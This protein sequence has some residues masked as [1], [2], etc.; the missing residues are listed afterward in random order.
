MNKRLPFEIREALI[1]VC[2]RSFHY[3]D[4]FRDFLISCDVPAEMYE[5]YS[6]D[7]KFKIARHLLA[8]LDSMGDGGYL[9]QKRIITNL[10]RF[11]KLPDENVPDRSA[12][13]NA[14]RNLKHLALDQKLIVIK[15][16]E[17]S[18]SGIQKAR[19]VKAALEARASKMQELK[20]RFTKL[21][22]SNDDPQSRGYSFEKVLA[23]LFSI[24]EI[25]YRPPYKIGTEQIDG[26]FN[27]KGFD[28]LVEARWRRDRP[29]EADLA[30]LKSKADKKIT[31]TR[32]LF[33]SIQGF[34]SEVVKEFT[35]GISSNLILMDGS[36]I[37]LILD[38]RISLI[39]ALDMKIEKAAQEGIIYFE[40]AKRFS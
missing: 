40:L 5:R 27:F 30:V 26:H 31:S 18:E 38:G 34:R 28:Y 11:R 35:R 32:G 7:S 25:T 6:D 4:P 36:D 24:Y 20:E 29:T 10:C 9:I 14:L 37:N 33:V 23:E 39:D 15:K 16:K 19:K 13:L 3:K 21:S 8:D 1:T 2:G 12:G 22:L 17:A